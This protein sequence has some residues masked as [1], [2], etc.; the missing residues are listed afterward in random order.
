M[1][2]L[3]YILGGRPHNFDDC[4]DLART[5]HPSRVR[6]QPIAEEWITELFVRHELV[7]EFCW[8]FSYGRCC[9]RACCGGCF[10]D[11][12]PSRRDARIRQAN[13]RLRRRVQQLTAIGVEVLGA[14]A[15]FTPEMIS[16]RP[17]GAA[18]A[19]PVTLGRPG[20]PIPVST[21]APQ[22]QQQPRQHRDRQAVDEEVA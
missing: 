22:A 9:C 2:S 18:A 14:E 8:E 11:D 20:D 19:E 6:L 15:R 4:V 10:A 12:P 7:G 3:R 5:R 21:E 16:T 1:R 17:G 13:R